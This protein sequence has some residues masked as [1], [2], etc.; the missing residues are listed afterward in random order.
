MHFT[1]HFYVIFFSWGNFSIYDIISTYFYKVIFLTL[2]ATLGYSLI[3]FALHKDSSLHPPSKLLLRY[4]TITD[5]CVGVIP[6]P[7]FITYILATLKE[8]SLS[9]NWTFGFCGKHHFSWSI[10]T[11]T[12]WNRFGQ[13]SCPVVEV[14]VQTSCDCQAS[15][16]CS[17][18]Q[19]MS[20]IALAFSARGSQV[21]SNL[22]S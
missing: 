10:V 21:D 4:L 19:F 5:L 12:D 18:S 2:I 22:L 16:C 11:H 3:L 1:Y 13:T 17:F 6:Q 20:K 15:F 14:T 7:S 8:N 9:R